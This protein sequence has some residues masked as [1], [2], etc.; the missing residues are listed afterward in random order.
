MTA[1]STPE[2]P[3]QPQLP[4][5]RVCSTNSNKKTRRELIPQPGDLRGPFSV[6]NISHQMDFVNLE[7]AIRQRQAEN[8]WSIFTTLASRPV[9][10]QEENEETL[11]YIPLPLCSEL[12]SLLTFAKTLANHGKP[13]DYRQKQIDTLLHYVEEE[14][15]MP[16][17][18]FMATAQVIPIPTYKLLLRAI[19]RRN[20]STSWDI[21]YDMS[22]VERTE[23]PR[24]TIFKLMTL[25]KN[26]FKVDKK[27]RQW[28]WTMIA[29]AHEEEES[30]EKIQQNMSPALLAELVW[31]ASEFNAVKPARELLMSISERR[32]EQGEPLILDEPAYVNLIHAHRDRKQYI[33]ALEVFERVLQDG[34]PPS[35]RAFNAALQVFSEQGQVDKSVYMFNSLIQLG[36]IPDIATY[37][38]MIKVHTKSGDLRTAVDYFYAMREKHFIQP[39]AYSYSLI[40]EAFSR[41]NDVKSVIRWFQSMLQHDIFPNHITVTNALKA[42][43]RQSRQYPNMGE[44]M[45]RIVGHAKAS[46]IKVDAHLYTLL[47]QVQ[48]QLNGLGGALATH[49]EMLDRLI[50]PNVYTYTVL[51]DICGR[52]DAPDAAQRIFELMKQSRVYLPNTHTY[53][54]MMDVLSRARR[55][56]VLK[57]LIQEFIVESQAN[58]DGRLQIDPKVRGYIQLY[59]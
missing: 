4:Q 48:A 17:S 33:K 59:N 34:T 36:I 30:D 51:I 9:Q 18:Q 28:R 44:A 23:I 32:K 24:T 38:E 54:A 19:K 47:L 41:R 15:E 7:R 3:P 55:H 52:Y 26:D 53:C 12:Y 6:F 27:E 49:R 21:F 22:P 1:L 2:L 57:D 25:V 39:N 50:E 43:Q 45:T 40:I 16:R 10:Q 35:I 29:E 46:G 56:D 42:F 58:D 37:S 11:R 13:S 31:R 8:A 14:F 5:Q 20:K